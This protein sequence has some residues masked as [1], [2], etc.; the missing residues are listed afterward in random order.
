MQSTMLGRKA[1]TRILSRTRTTNNTGTASCALFPHHQANNEFFPTTSALHYGIKATSPVTISVHPSTTASLAP[2]RWEAYGQQQANQNI[3]TNDSC[4]FYLSKSLP[5]GSFETV[6]NKNR[7]RYTTSSG[8][9]GATTLYNESSSSSELV[10]IGIDCCRQGDA[11]QAEDILDMLQSR[12]DVALED[13]SSVKSSIIGAWV[14]N[15]KQSLRALEEY[16]TTD[17]SQHDII[18]HHLENICHAADSA[19][20]VLEGINKDTS[21]SNSKVGN[22]ETK[23]LFTLVLQ[24]WAN[25]TEARFKTKLP[26]RITT[27][28][29]IEGIPQRMN[30]FLR[31]Q[32]VLQ[33][34]NSEVE[35]TNQILKAWACSDEHLRGTMAEQAFKSIEEPNGDSFRW[36]IRAWCWSNER[37][38]AFTATGHHMRMLRL[39]ETTGRADMAPTMDDYHVLFKTWTTA[40]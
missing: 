39:F 10:S 33:N 35:W 5:L 20:R 1:V 38:R 19:S 15:Q 13:L 3:G 8:K 40:G 32:G 17:N 7:R 9:S 11:D 26:R 29:M 25:C 14:Q 22:V 12:D 21:I 16:T 27:K 28:V 23:Q 36:I 18:L 2:S 6:D 4:L 30:H 24:A 34:S 37:P 31:Q